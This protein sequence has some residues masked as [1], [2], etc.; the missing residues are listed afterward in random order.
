MLRVDFF[1]TTNKKKRIGCV[2]GFYPKKEEK[3]KSRAVLFCGCVCLKKR[4]TKQMASFCRNSEHSLI[5]T[6]KNLI[7][8]TRPE[9]DI[10]IAELIW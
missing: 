3:I 4:P 5:T 9:I 6:I 7:L 10:Q 1:Q 8:A 2:S